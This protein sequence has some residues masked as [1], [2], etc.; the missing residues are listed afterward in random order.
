MADDKD[1]DSSGLSSAGEE[2]IQKLAPI[3]VNAKKANKQRFPPPHVSP[4]RPKRPPSPPR[5][6]QFADNPDIAFLVMFRSRFNEAMPSKLTQM[7]PQD[8]ERGVT[9]QP[10][11]PQ[12]ESLLCALLALVLN[13]KKPVERGHHGRA[14]EECISTMKPQW[15]LSWHGINPLHG[16]RDFTTMPPSERL[17]LLRTLVHW[18][19]TSSEAIQAIIKDR[20]KQQRHQDDENQPLSV[21]PWGIDGDK[22][23][24]FLIQ[25]ADDTTGFRIYRESGRYLTKGTA[26]WINEGGDIEELKQLAAKLNDVDGS[27]AARRLAARML[28]AVPTFEASEEKRR[29]KEYRQLKRAQFERPEPGFSLYEGRTRG[30]R[31]RYTYDDDDDMVFGGGIDS[32]A[33][34]T[35]RSARNRDSSARTTPFEATGPTFTASGRQINKPKTGEYGEPLLKSALENATDELAPELEDGA[36]GTD[37]DSEPVH[38]GRATRAAGRSG[39]VNGVNGRKRKRVIDDDEDDEE[40]EMSDE[41]GGDGEDDWDSDRNAEEEDDTEMPDADDEDSEDHDEESQSLVVKL[42]VSPQRGTNGESKEEVNGDGNND[43]DPKPIPASKTQYD[44]HGNNLI[45]PPSEQNLQAPHYS[46]PPEQ[47]APG[48]ESTSSTQPSSALPPNGT[49]TTTTSNLL[50][51]AQPDID[52]SSSAPYPT[53]A[54]STAVTAAEKLSPSQPQSQE[55]ETA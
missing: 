17:N 22:R 53:P 54:T 43:E 29:R 39:H 25:G 18:A 13:R 46:S 27:Q 21:Q 24:Y 41:E 10:P 1:S 9:D 52:P 14:L 38:N 7:G 40:G 2:E 3:F 34:S 42:K 16:P 35:R 49:N 37:F 23:R 28:N 55:P 6:E 45:H 32:D 26:S 20:Y 47:A 15:P 11:S 12:V 4:P 19:L 51:S 8:I 50:T 30:K 33:T 48:A 36:T 5:E 44:T 31:L